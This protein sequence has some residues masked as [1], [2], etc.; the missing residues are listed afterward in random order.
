MPWSFIDSVRKPS[1]LQ[2]LMDM[3]ESK[4]QDSVHVT[5]SKFYNKTKIT[6]S[7]ITNSPWKKLSRN[8][9]NCLTVKRVRNNSSKSPLMLVSNHLRVVAKLLIR[10]DVQVML[11]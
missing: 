6:S 7:K 8:L 10:L 5:L 3:E 1:F 9:M 11:F 4:Y 2:S